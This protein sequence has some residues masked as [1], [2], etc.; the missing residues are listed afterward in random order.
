MTESRRYFGKYRGTVFN[1]VDPEQRGRMLAIVPDVLGL[2]PTTWA[3]PCVPLA[4]PSGPPM[5]AYF[6]PPIGAGVWVEFE[7]G[8]PNF[9]IWAGCRFGSTADV[10]TLALAG[11]P[12]SPSIVLQ[13]A[14]QNCIAISDLPGPTGGIMLKSTTGATLIV[15]DTGIYIQNGKGA[16]LTLVGPTVTVNTGALTVT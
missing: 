8:D 1:N 15:N 5:G 12:I 16:S 9:P 11:L 3:E 13:T 14:G 6:M 10:P 4:G 7:Q 2:V